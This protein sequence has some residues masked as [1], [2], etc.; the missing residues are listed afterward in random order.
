MARPPNWA[1]KIT[2]PEEALE[3]YRMIEKLQTSDAFRT[4]HIYKGA[5]L[6]HVPVISWRGKVT[7][8]PRI[9]LGFLGIPYRKSICKNHGCC[10]PFHYVDLDEER[11]K[12]LTGMAMPEK[13]VYRGTPL[14]DYVQTVEYVLDANGYPPETN[15]FQV[16]R[17]LIPRGDIPDELLQQTLEH[18]KN[19]QR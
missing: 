2:A 19:E 4:C 1:S 10:N 7:A 17:H 6:N 12:P 14:E 16:I 5:A 11:P 9:V 3:F 13:E 15:D 8:L 18:M